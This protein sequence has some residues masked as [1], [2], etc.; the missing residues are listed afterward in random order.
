MNK[1]LL[2]ITFC[3][4][5]MLITLEWCVVLLIIALMFSAICMEGLYIKVC[6]VLRYV[7]LP[8]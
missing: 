4:C 2:N 1:G 3:K 6:N 5:D 7:I 8:Y